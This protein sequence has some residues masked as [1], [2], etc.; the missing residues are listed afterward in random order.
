[1]EERLVVQH[2]ELNDP[3]HPRDRIDLQREDE[4]LFLDT[5]VGAQDI[6]TWSIMMPAVYQLVPGSVISK[7]WFLAIFPTNPLDDNPDA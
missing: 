7:F 2:Q 4:D 1:M 5:I 6:N 3:S